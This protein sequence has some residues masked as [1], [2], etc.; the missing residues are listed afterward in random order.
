MEALT[1]ASLTVAIIAILL[2]I[3]AARDARNN[4]DRTKDVLANIDKS[5]G[6]IQETVSKHQTELLKTVTEL[7][8]PHQDVNKQMEGEFLKAF[9]SNPKKFESMMSTISKLSEQQE[10]GKKGRG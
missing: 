6:L 5:S 4:Y 1:V 2:S 9:I 8:V 3:L 7:A 10:Q